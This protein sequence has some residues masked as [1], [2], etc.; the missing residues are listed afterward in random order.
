MLPAYA[1]FFLRYID[2]MRAFTV[3]VVLA[4]LIASP[5]SS[6]VLATDISAPI[7]LDIRPVTASSQTS[8]LPTA[9]DATE[10]SSLRD[11]VAQ[12]ETTQALL[13]PYD[14]TL[15]PLWLSLANRA[16]A[17]GD[18]EQAALL[19][20]RS[21]HNLRLN[22]GLTSLTQMD[23]L[24]NWIASLR[25]IGDGETLD[26]QLT[27]RY[28]L[29]GFGAEP[30]NEQRLAYAVD[31]LDHRLHRLTQGNWINREREVL[32]LLEHV[33][34]LSDDA[35]FD[36]VTDIKWCKPLLKRHLALLY[37][38]EHRVEPFID[39]ERRPYFPPP[40]DPRD[41]SNTSYQLEYEE[42]QAFRKGNRLLQQLEQLA[43]D[44]VEVAL[45]Y[46]DWR[47][48]HGRTTDANRRYQSIWQEAPELLEVAEP[49]PWGLSDGVTMSG[50]ADG[51]P[52]SLLSYTVSSL[53]KPRNIVSL[54]GDERTAQRIR[55]ALRKVKFRPAFEQ[56]IRVDSE[57]QQRYELVAPLP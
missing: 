55:K 14:P 9:I 57:Q 20:Q 34:G 41:P 45:I 50:G 4:G 54:D 24:E 23:A 33:S 25:E 21:L 1:G 29:V 49:L 40:R 38:I 42:T 27:Y 43:V 15:A 7:G 53:G 3:K 48:I 8:K 11:A 31:F 10:L 17:L 39:D 36:N 28:R 44:D 12:A 51:R 5:W 30:W 52:T 16:L 6:A 13:G 22:E 26:E 32:W 18:E 47:W 19:F 56:G 35:C 46:A 37:Y 2:A